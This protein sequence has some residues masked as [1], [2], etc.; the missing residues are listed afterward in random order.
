MLHVSKIEV[1]MH[2]QDMKELVNECSDALEKTVCAEFMGQQRGRT[3]F[4]EV[5]RQ[6]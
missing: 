1:E 5:L 6:L 3:G 4:Q 2:E